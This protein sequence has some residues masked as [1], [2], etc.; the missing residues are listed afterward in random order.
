MRRIYLDNAATTPVD[1]RVVEAMQR[2]FTESFGNA[3]SV[4]WFGQQSRKDL[5][6]ARSIIAASIGATP[7]EIVFTSGGTEADNFAIRGA[8]IAGKKHGRGHVVTTAAEHHAVLDCVEA[9]RD[10]G[11]AIT[12]L[13]VDQYG[14]TSA[15]EVVRALSERTCLVSVMQANNEVGTI[16]D[17]PSIASVVHARGALLH[18]DAVQAIGKIPV[19]VNCLGVDLLTMT[20]HKI[21][22]PKGIGALYIRKG[23]EIENILWGGG[24]ERGRRP[25]TENVALAV[26]FAKAVEFGRAEMDSVA[27]SLRLLRDVLQSQLTRAIPELLVNGHPEDRLPHILNVSV[28]AGRRPLEGETLQLSLDLEGI[29]VSSGSACTSGSVQPSHVLLAMGR[30]P[31]TAKATLRFSF[32]KSNTEDDI[33]QV[34]DAL[35]SVIARS[36]ART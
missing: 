31:A 4:H 19:D 35:K 24:Q 15:E 6:D 33:G 32:G 29:A 23:T 27:P 17:L 20:A 2:H 25:G 9:L 28:D 22:G 11:A 18:T 21:Y 34:V 8:F 3:S 30:S 13:P 7:G 16:S 36:R 26:G 1:P 12:V 14:R 5:E 10:D